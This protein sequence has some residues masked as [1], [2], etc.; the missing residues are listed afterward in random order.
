[1]RRFV[2]LLLALSAVNGCRREPPAKQ[3][4]RAAAADPY[5]DGQRL[6]AESH[7]LS[8]RWQ[9]AAKLVDCDALLTAAAERG[10]CQA[11]GEAVREL[12]QALQRRE[13]PER[14]TRLAAEAA[15]R[16][17]RTSEALRQAGLVRLFEER[18]LA[19]AAPP[20]TAS[21]ASVANA[22]SPLGGAASA[23]GAHAHAPARK[24]DNADI[25][26]IQ[27]YARAANLGLRQL[28]LYLEFGPLTLR[29]AAC[30]ELERLVREQPNWAALEALVGEARLV[31]VNAAQRARLERLAEQLRSK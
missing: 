19:G 25:A 31:E 4:R 28:A 6:A 20:S 21:A 22:P 8:E 9:S 14:L 13:A 18:K 23:H 11:A 5:A 10:A 29:N 16:T 24:H 30:T 7:T 1:M 27:S 17:Q 15:L 26:A 2:V 3:E 12:L